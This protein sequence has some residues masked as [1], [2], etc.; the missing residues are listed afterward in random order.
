MVIQTLEDSAPLATET[1]KIVSS[2]GLITTT[3]GNTSPSI[4]LPVP[5]VNADQYDRKE[6]LTWQLDCF[7]GREV[8]DG[9]V[10]LGG[11]ENRACGGVASTSALRDTHAAVI[12]ADRGTL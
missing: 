4:V 6:Y 11:A 12:H 7:V 9:L 2:A 5:D 8:M 10:L 3:K 1:V